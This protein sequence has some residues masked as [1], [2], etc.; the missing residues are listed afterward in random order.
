[1][2]SFL[3][4]CSA[5]FGPGAARLPTAEQP[6][7]GSTALFAGTDI[8][9]PPGGLPQ[10]RKSKRHWLA[11]WD[12]EEAADGFMSS[13]ATYFPELAGAEDMFALKLIP[14]MQRGAE[15]LRLQL[16]ARPKPDEPIVIIT[17][18]GAYASEPDAIAA[19]SHASLARESLGETDGLARD[20]LLFPF[21]AMATDLFTITAWKNEAAAQAW[22]YRTT[23]HRGAMAFYKSAADKPRVSFTRCV[24]AHS[25]GDWRIPEGR[26]GSAL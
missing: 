8:D 6:P 3:S 15:I 26:D 22:A 19:S 24:I 5:T 13:P 25:F 2:S 18:I 10:R 9:Y 11:A 16:G 17:S 20:L 14:Y 12:T 21:G 7:A 4:L 23:A 1:M